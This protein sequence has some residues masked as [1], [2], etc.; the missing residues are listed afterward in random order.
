VFANKVVVSNSMPNK[1]KGLSGVGKLIPAE[2]LNRR[3]A[4]RDHKTG[5]ETVVKATLTATKHDELTQSEAVGVA[6]E[7]IQRFGIEGALLGYEKD[8]HRK[9]NLVDDNMDIDPVVYRNEVHHNFSTQKILG[10]FRT[11]KS[12]KNGE[13]PGALL[14]AVAMKYLGMD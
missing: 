14:L 13:I 10:I 9:F 6:L 11:Y 2:E 7:I 1:I 12:E 5:S 8:R 3:R 4:E